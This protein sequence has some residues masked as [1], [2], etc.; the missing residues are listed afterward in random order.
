MYLLERESGFNA[1]RVIEARD[2]SID[3]LRKLLSM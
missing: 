2:S 3:G 1:K